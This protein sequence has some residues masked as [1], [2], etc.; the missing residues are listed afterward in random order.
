MM[1]P[2]PEGASQTVDRVW[3]LGDRSGL[4]EDTVRGMG[5]ALNRRVGCAPLRTLYKLLFYNNLYEMDPELSPG[6]L[7]LGF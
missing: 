2:A 4:S 6:L 7:E 3:V 5:M 1:T